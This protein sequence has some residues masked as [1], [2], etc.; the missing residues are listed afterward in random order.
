MNQL[1][2]IMQQVKTLPPQDLVKVI[3]QAAE[4]L[5]QKWTAAESPAVDYVAFLGAG[6]GVFESLRTVSKS[7]INVLKGGD[8]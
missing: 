1:E 6:K 7:I 2:I 4:L 3:P 8:L 5:E